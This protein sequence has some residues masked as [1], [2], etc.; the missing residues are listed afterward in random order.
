[1]KKKKL[2]VFLVT[3]LKLWS[4]NMM[5]VVNITGVEDSDE[6][7]VTATYYVI[8]EEMEEA[9]YFKENQ[10]SMKLE[11]VHSEAQLTTL[12]KQEGNI[13]QG[14]IHS[15]IRIPDNLAV[16]YKQ[17]VGELKINELH[18]ALTIQHG[19]G[20]ISL[21]NITGPIQLTDG[22]GSI[23]LERV[24]GEV[25]LNTNSGTTTLANTNGDIT[26]MAGSGHINVNDH[27]GAIVVEVDQVILRLLT[28]MVM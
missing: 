16:V 1:M 6:I 26:I 15:D 24:S 18:S 8:G 17:S 21:K 27:E 3:A 13:E 12:I 5:K 10:T 25:N 7:E 28:L 20:P 22:A 14:R 4:F 19:S 9:Q 11:Q 2:K 23:S